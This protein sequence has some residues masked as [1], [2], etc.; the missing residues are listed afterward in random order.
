[1]FQRKLAQ[2][3]KPAHIASMQRMMRMMLLGGGLW[4]ANFAGAQSLSAQLTVLPFVQANGVID[5]SL[6]ANW[7]F[8]TPGF[9]SSRA[10]INTQFQAYNGVPMN[11]GGYSTYTRAFNNQSVPFLGRTPFV[12]GLFRNRAQFQ[13]RAMG[14]FT[15]RATTVDPAGNPTFR[16]GAQYRLPIPKM[17][18]LIPPTQLKKP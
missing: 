15:V 10:G 14:N 12:G 13:R 5:M 16:P 2:S 8:R 11:I 9:G 3:D 18:G 1:M 6:A 4:L 7:T 17:Y